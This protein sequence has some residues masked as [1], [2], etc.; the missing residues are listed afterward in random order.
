M[1]YRVEFWRSQERGLALKDAREFTTEG[2]AIR[3]RKELEKM[4]ARKRKP[5]Q[6][7]IV[8]NISRC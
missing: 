6:V 1:T 5:G 7:C 3:F 4:A 2:E 8:G